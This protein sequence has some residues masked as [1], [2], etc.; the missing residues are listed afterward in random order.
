VTALLLC[1]L[2]VTQQGVAGLPFVLDAASD[3]YASGYVFVATRYGIY[4][5]DRNTETWGRMNPPDSLRRWNGVSGF[6]DEMWRFTAIGVDEGILWVAAEAG[7]ASADIK[8]GDWQVAAVPGAIRGL[9]FDDDYAWAGGDSG[10][11]RFDKYSETWSL[12]ST[13]PVNDLLAEKGFIWVATPSGI[14]RYDTRYDKAEPMPAPTLNYTHIVNNA[15]RIWFLSDSGAASFRKGGETWTNYPVFGVTSLSSAGDSLFAIAGGVPML[16]DPGADFWAPVRDFQPPRGP[17]GICWSGADLWLAADSGLRVYNKTANSTSDYTLRNGLVTDSLL[18]VYADSRF[19][20][21]VS[22]GDI[23]F[24]DRKTGLWRIET[25]TATGRKS[26]QVISLDDAGAHLKLVKDTDIRLSGRAYYE[27]SYAFTETGRSDAANRSINLN[28]AGQH[29]NGRSLSLYY[30]DSD[31]DDVRYGLGFRGVEGD[32]L[33]RLDAGRLKSGYADFDLVPQFSLV[34]AD[35]RL[36]F[37]DHGLGL[38]AG[39]IESQLHSEYFTG[40]SVEKKTSVFDVYY[41]KGVFFGLPLS[42]RP[43]ADTVFADDR[44]PATN[45]LKTRVGFTLSGRTGDYDVLVSGTDYFVDFDNRLIHFV[46]PRKPAEVVFYVAGSETLTLQRDTVSTM[47]TSAYSFGP[48]ITPGTFELAIT[49]TLG[50][51]H[52]LAEFGLDTDSDGKVDDRFINLDLG[53]LRFPSERPFPPA[54]YDE[55]THV[56]TLNA[57][58][59]SRSAFY[60]L[61]YK[62]LVRSS[63]QVRVDGELM[64]RGSDYIV[65]YTSGILLFLRKDV[66]SDF[67]QVDVRYSSSTPSLPFSL[68]PS[69]VSAQPVIAVSDAISIAPGF[70]RVEDENIVHLS[71]RV[72]TGAGTDRSVR[73]IPQIA[74]SSQ[75]QL[76]VAQD[77]SASAN[78]GIASASAQYRGYTSS[79]DAFGAEDRRYGELRHSAAL[80]A[81]VEPV[82]HLRFDAQFLREYQ[83]DTLMEAPPWYHPVQYV[84]GKASYSNPAFPTGY[85]LVGK[86]W[87]PDAEK[88]RLKAVGGYEVRLA[89]SRLKLDALVHNVSIAATDENA[90]EYSGEAT[91]SLPIPVQ[92]NLRFR[93]NNLTAATARRRT[94]RELRGRLN[95]DAV[96]GFFYAGSYEL[97]SAASPLESSQDIDLSGLLYNNLQIAPGRWW[98]GLSVVN[99]SVGTGSNFDQYLR[100][101]APEF[102]T[103]FLLARPLTGQPVSSATDQEN[104]YGTIQLTPVSEVT[105]RARHNIIHGG[106]GLY[107][108]P[109]LKAGTEDEVKVEYEPSRLGLF[110]AL[111]NLRAAAGFP[112]NRLQ[113]VY[114]EWSMPWSQLLRTKLTTTWQA[115]A[116]YYYAGSEANT[117]TITPKAEAL[118]RFGSRSLATVNLG[119]SHTSAHSSIANRQSQMALLPGAGFNLNLF[120]F[121]YLQMDYQG[122]LPDSGAATH[123]LSA[124]I[125]GQF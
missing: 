72:E 81:G 66:I 119:L 42:S 36:R 48:N 101:L 60:F 106:T 122:S 88:L 70:S 16:Y 68:T 59:E 79:F 32:A 45:G 67:S 53:F 117:N 56:Y 87:L 112:A 12:R 63:E 93:Q 9:A 107:A 39:R 6:D 37:R 50:V 98:S 15:G 118:F 114:F 20:F 23:Q 46:T 11:W 95:V 97:T 43:A 104:I 108:L 58:F 14:A 115:D 71:G 2:A 85:L 76:G 99:L 38:Q 121:L 110:T 120:R 49:D 24:L 83:A 92:G 124:K 94:E 64:A 77:Y 25:F 100:G 80:N 90:L 47:L 125:T 10:L 35:A 7:L 1:L 78:Y 21:A 73:F 41:A 55:T 82:R 18:A 40:R 8:L 31:K 3:P 30:D 123:S 62:P 44:N 109:A 61:Q 103:P 84:S 113:N 33:R 89:R 105:L 29:A 4:T 57:R 27:R 74:V 86:D 54:V 34:G 5:F 22:D 116:D 65:D 102:S 69:L 28:L 111:W 17:L 91:F 26:T 19:V 51:V 96:P 75:S 52:P 13:T